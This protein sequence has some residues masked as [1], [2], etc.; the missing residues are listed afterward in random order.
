MK[1][2]QKKGGLIVRLIDIVL[3]LLFG[4]ISISSLDTKS[5]VR[6]SETTDIP[7]TNIDEEEILVIAI[8]AED[9]FR[10]ESVEKET[11]QVGTSVKGLKNIKKIILQKNAQYQ[12]IGKKMKV[13]IRANWYLPI[14][15]AMDLALFCDADSIEKSIDVRIVPKK[16]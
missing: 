16:K 7:Q 15:Y 9:M 12:K 13:R 14:K 3:I 1:Q 2:D 10:I 6:L 4:F 5:D 8:P 11:K